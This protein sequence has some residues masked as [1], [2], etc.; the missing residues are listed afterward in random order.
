[1]LMPLLM[2]KNPKDTFIDQK[3][4]VLLSV[5]LSLFHI[6]ANLW[7]AEWNPAGSFCAILSPSGAVSD[8]TH[9]YS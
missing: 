4:N 5:P 3:F 7:T 9:C 6:L 2:K 8:N 1:M